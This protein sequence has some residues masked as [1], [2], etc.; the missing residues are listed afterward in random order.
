MRT[1]WTSRGAGGGGAGPVRRSERDALVV[2]LLGDPGDGLPA[3]RTL[4]L[5][6][7]WRRF[8]TAAPLH[9]RLGFGAATI[10]VAIVV[11]RLLGHGHGLAHLDPD[12]ADAVVQRAA[13]LPLVNAVI[14]VAKIVACF[15]YFSDDRVDEAVRRGT[16]Q[17]RE[18]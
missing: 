9:L 2:A 10:L 11:P 7:F 16:S 18:T 6:R 1:G 17:E 15:A 14:E 12:A 4:D 8:E 5:E 3:P 13:G